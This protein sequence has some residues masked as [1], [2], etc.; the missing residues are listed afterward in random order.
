MKISWHHSFGYIPDILLD[1]LPYVIVPLF[2]YIAV[3]TFILHTHKKE[4]SF[5]RELL[6]VFFVIYAAT[7]IKL[8]I[9]PDWVFYRDFD[10]K[11][12]M[13]YSG[14]G[15]HVPVNLVP[16]KNILSFLR[17]EVHVNK[18]DMVMVVMLNLVGGIVLFCPLGF[19]LPTFF[20]K[21]QNWKAV[22]LAGLGCS[23]VIETIQ[24]FIGRAADVDDMLLNSIGVLGGYCAY[25]IE[26]H[27]ILDSKLKLEEN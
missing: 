17:G 4:V 9:I 19:F 23:F 22:V 24:F 13:F 26:K 18:E 15:N 10:T 7:V 27:Y 6:Y 16:L 14:V 21:M 2:L 8:T 3:R 25:Q 1:T 5:R 20:P 12:I 11:K